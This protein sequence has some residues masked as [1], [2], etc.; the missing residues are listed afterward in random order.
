MA[1]AA[2]NDLLG[3]SEDDWRLLF[4][5]NLNDK[6]DAVDISVT[7]DEGQPVTVAAVDFQGFD[8]IPPDHLDNLR[9][10]IPM[11]AG[12][13]RDRQEVVSAHEMAVNELRARYIAA[14]HAADAGDYQPLLDFLDNA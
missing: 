14:L 2:S 7:I 4:D 6:Q 9:K 5:V 8:V 1:G 3:T 12:M 11:T 13:P 10:R